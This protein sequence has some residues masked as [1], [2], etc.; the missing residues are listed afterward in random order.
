[1]IVK[2][3][4]ERDDRSG[5]VWELGPDNPRGPHLDPSVGL[6]ADRVEVWVLE[7]SAHDIVAQ[8]DHCVEYR[9]FARGQEIARQPVRCFFQG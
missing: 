8:H 1:L 7:E 3:F 5:I 9:V 2:K 4:Y 6:R